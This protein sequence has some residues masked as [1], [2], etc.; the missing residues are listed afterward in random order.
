MLFNLFFHLSATDTLLVGIK[1]L[2]T[3]IR[4]MVQNEVGEIFIQL[5]DQVFKLENENL[6]KTN[7]K[8]SADDEI[9]FQDGKF[10]S[11]NRL[12]RLKEK[13]QYAEN[14]CFKWNKFLAKRALRTMG[15]I[16]RMN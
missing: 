2:G 14:H 12:N 10:T 13:I 9:F 1:D 5:G 4:S 11:I 8:I 7:I 6:E 3:P 15:Y 16:T